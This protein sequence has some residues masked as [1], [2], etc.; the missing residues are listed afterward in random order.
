MT[1]ARWRYPIA[2][3]LVAVAVALV[4]AFPAFFDARPGP[5]FLLAPVLTGWIGGRGPGAVAGVLGVLAALAFGRVE[6]GRWTVEPVAVVGQALALALA[7]WVG[8]LR[9]RT[10]PAQQPA[11]EPGPSE[12]ALDLSRLHILSDVSR[13]L[14]ET[15]TGYARLLPGAAQAIAS[16]CRDFCAIYVPA[17]GG[18]LEAAAHWDADPDAYASIEPHVSGSRIPMDAPLVRD[19][20]VSGEPVLFHGADL[21][22]LKPQIEPGMWAILEG[23]RATGLMVA[24]L[25]KGDEALGLLLLARHRPDLPPYDRADLLLA[26]ELAHRV[27]LALG[28]A[29]QF[30]QMSEQRKQFGI[31]LS[32]IA[33][34]VI[35]TDPA[36]RITFMNGQA[37]AL[38]GWPQH[39]AQGRPLEAV[40][41]MYDEETGAP[42]ESP[43]QRAVRENLVVKP[44]TQLVLARRDGTRRP[45][46]GSAA[47]I[48]DE[49]G[50]L[51]GVVFV[52]RDVTRERE[53]GRI[54]AG[55]ERRVRQI[56]DTLFLMVVVL[57]PDGVVLDA[58]SAALELAGV[59]LE[60]VVGKPLPETVWWSYAAEAQ[61][62][63]W[64][65]IRRAAQGEVVRQDVPVNVDGRRFLLDFTLAP[66]FDEQCRVTH[67]IGS[68]LDITARKSIEEALRTSEERLQAALKN[69]PV[70]V[71]SQDRELRYTWLQDALHGYTTE[72]VFGK[73]DEEIFSPEEAQVLHALKQQ[74]LDTGVGVRQE[75]MLHYGGEAHYFDLSIEP[76]RD[77]KGEITGVVC[78]GYD[79]T[80]RRQE[81]IER[82]RLFVQAAEERDRLRT[83]IE[84]VTDEVWF[85]DAHGNLELV[86]AAVVETL[87]ASSA[88]EVHGPL[89]NL[90]DRLQVFH[91]DGRPRALVDAPLLRSLRGEVIRNEIEIL[92]S[93]TT[94]ELCYRRVS[95]VPFSN[96]AGEV[97]GAVAVVHDITEEMRVQDEI[98]TL[99]AE[100]EQRVRERTAQLHAVN[101]ELEAFSYSVSHDLRTPLRAIDGFSLALLEDYGDVLDQE[102]RFHL[103]RIRTASQRL[104]QLIDDLLKLSRLTRSDIEYAPVDLSAL[105]AEVVDELREADPDR[106]VTVTIQ[107]NVIVQGDA[108]LLRVVLDN[109][110]SNAWKFTGRTPQPRIEFGTLDYD[111]ESVYYVRDNGAGFDM[112]YIEKLFRAFQRLHKTSEFE[113]TGIGLATVQRIIHRHG[114]RIWAQAEVGEGA[115]FYFTLGTDRRGQHA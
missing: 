45:I 44:P 74:V 38:T 73:R 106:E 21:A 3:G 97:L 96:D 78:A 107:P 62:Q 76:M 102:G 112:A 60:D 66:M 99:N 30:Q 9:E 103:G 26:G 1:A 2:I 40:A 69:A 4:L 57:T 51:T 39:M 35:A 46:D 19:A 109:L 72:L 43:V 83:L 12:A 58:N 18:Q 24:P 48:R 17:D 41:P 89:V 31:T 93:P 98:R 55:S 86:N 90:L 8:A 87:G 52:F 28:N 20:L 115:T 15:T 95:S 91:A 32:S 10:T 79:V 54:L 53:A 34:A 81:A 33:D 68:A 92:R 70:I 71:C 29:R 37:E 5:L 114:G 84:N 85:C 61:Q 56:L 23:A 94:G 25:R 111:D 101:R 14:A 11:S 49:Q 16:A 22:R 13:K 6:D 65:V 105:A 113:G 7:V 108:R 104:G 80:A 50:E 64:D 47:P 27:G 63:L 82:E 59:S 100:L 88:A 77:E 42:V 67:L 36:G 110:F 75:V